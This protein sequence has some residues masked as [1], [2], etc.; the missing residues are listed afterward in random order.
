MASV[1]KLKVIY[2]KAAVLAYSLISS[3]LF[4]LSVAPFDQW[5]F[6]YIAFVPM[7][8]LMYNATYI[9]SLAQITIT[10]II[11]G[12]VWSYSVIAYSW[13]VYFQILGIVWCGFAVWCL[14]TQY[15]YKNV[16]Q[17]KWSFLIPVVIWVGIERFLTSTYVGV[18]INI[19][20]TQ[21]NQPELIQW[22]SFFGIYTIS[23]LIILMNSLFAYS[24]VLYRKNRSAVFISLVPAALAIVLFAINFSY[25]MFK[26][27]QEKNLNKIKVAVIQPVISSEIYRNSGRSYEDRQYIKTVLNQLTDDAVSQDIDM[28]FWP[29]GGNGH[30]SMRIDDDR[31]HFY[32]VARKNKADIFISSDDIDSEGN[33]FNS[34]FSISK[35]G[36]YKGRY[37][38]VHLI[39]GAEDSYTAG[40]EHS[41]VASSFG[42]IGV[43]ICYETNFS[44]VFRQSVDSGAK[45]LFASTSDSAF[46]KTSL[47]ISHTNMS[48]FRA[49]ENNRWLVHASNTGPSMIVSPTGRIIARINMYERGG[50]FGEIEAKE[51][52]SVFT[53]WGYIVP[54]IFSIAVFIMIIFLLFKWMLA[55]YNFFR[56]KNNINYACLLKYFGLFLKYAYAPIIVIIVTSALVF[57]SVL[58]V[59]NSIGNDE[60]VKEVLFD[61]FQPLVLHKDTISQR[62]LQSQDNTCG[63][64]ALAYILNYYGVDTSE[65]EVV[66]HVAMSRFGTSMLQLKKAANNYGFNGVGFQG[67]YLW[68]ENQTLPLMAHVNDKH[69][70]VIN[71][72]IDNRVYLFDPLEG[73]VILKKNDFENLWS[74]NVL[75]VRPKPIRPAI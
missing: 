64:A 56:Y 29:E 39:N 53:R 72:I 31:N 65:T 44:E 36:L 38:K 12:T 2:R 62:F 1:E 45:I 17:G 73:H 13:I 46:K 7:L 58:V 50:I 21:Y 3:L 5:Y 25:G 67:N 57:S 9:K 37:D 52:T 71:K 15:L 49:V 48:V 20:I 35:N 4:S 54:L 55:S 14:L 30:I 75:T 68:L 63:P 8:Y 19:G 60:S 41:P 34:V 40:N 22:A 74:G 27:D 70:V 51:V 28:L 10:A 43:A 47:A 16:Y 26:L 18:P 66:K 61:I 11:I 59:K 69:Y 32:E 33:K 42:D 24:I 23:L 6:A